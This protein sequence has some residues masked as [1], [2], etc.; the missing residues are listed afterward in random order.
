MTK[1]NDTRV[2]NRLT[3]GGYSADHSLGSAP[4]VRAWWT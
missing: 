3:R 1:N 4:E 2:N